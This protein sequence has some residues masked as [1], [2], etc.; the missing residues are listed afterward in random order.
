MTGIISRRTALKASTAIAVLGATACGKNNQKPSVKEDLSN[1]DAVGTAQVIRDGDVTASEVVNAAID[2]AEQL[3][4]KLNAIVTPYF[5]SARDRAEE[6]VTGPWA[7]VPTFVKDLNN[8]IG[9]RT[10]YGAKAFSNHIASTQSAFVDAYL[11]TGMVSLGKSSTPEFGLNATTETALMGATRNPWNLNHSSGGS[12]GGAAAL[13]ASHIVPVAHASD[14]GGSI[15]IPAACCGLVGLK[16]SAFRFPEPERPA[17]R[18]VRI[19]EHGIE[20]RSVRD[21]AAFF[22]MMEV[23]SDHPEVGLVEGPS[24][25]RRKIGLY[26]APSS[27][28]EI[29]PEVEAATRRAGEVLAALGHDVIE[30]DTPFTSTVSQDFGIYWASGAAQAVNN[31]ERAVGRK[32]GYDDFESWTFGLIDQYNMRPDSLG[33]A[34]ARLASFA[35]QWRAAFDDYDIMLSPVL[36]TPA[37]PLGHLAPS[38]NFDLVMER[39][40]AY[41]PY[42]HFANIAAAPAISLPLEQPAS[43]LPIG[44]MAAAVQGADRALIELAFELEEAMPWKGRKAPHSA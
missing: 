15:R 39:I 4:P 40:T 41:S 7:G 5:E 11:G 6:G 25:V 16:P 44:V 42:T 28:T 17:G 27:G 20:A 13:V 30:I 31:W 22:A 43:G 14:G 34:V 23:E 29:D 21:V 38:A 26:T 33:D 19:S 10:S 1:L 12:S 8:V 32:A 18:P 37:A 35:D 9:Q 24:T 3:N 36:A 2:R